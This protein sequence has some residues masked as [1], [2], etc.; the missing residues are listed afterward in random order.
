M[1]VDLEGTRLSSTRLEDEDHLVAV[2]I[3]DAVRAWAQNPQ[4]NYGVVLKAEGP[5]QVRYT[6]ASSD[7]AD[8]D[9]HPELRITYI[10]SSLPAARQ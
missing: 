10:V 8:V 2:D 4:S 9:W 5:V 1:G 7:H 6:I 3:T